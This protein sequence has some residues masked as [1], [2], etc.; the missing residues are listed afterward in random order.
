MEST[1]LL[2]LDALRESPFNPRRTFNQAALQELADTMKPPHGA[3][4]QP[5][6]VRPLEQ[7]DIEHSHEIVFG[8]RRCRAAR[9]AGLTVIPAIVRSMA[10][11]DVK[12]AQIVE[13]LQRE[14]VS[15][16]EE[17]DGFKTLR[18][19]HGVSIEVLM[20]QTGKS[21]S[22]IFNRLKLATAHDDVR[23]AVQ[24]GLVCAEIGQELAR[25]PNP[26]Q[27]KALDEVTYIDCSDGESRRV[28]LSV[29]RAKSIL[30]ERYQLKLTAAPF[31][32]LKLELVPGVLAC[33]ACPKRSDAEPTL[34]ADMGPDVC[35]DPD[36]FAAKKAATMAQRVEAMRAAGHTVLDGDAAKELMPTG[37]GFDLSKA[38]SLDDT[39]FWEPSADNP[40]QQHRVTWREAVQRG[41]GQAPEVIHV[42]HPHT[43]EL[44]EAI[45]ASEADALIAGSTD[46][47]DDE[48]AQLQ[49]DDAHA[50]PEER[51]V[52]GQE[53]WRKT[54]AAIM[55]SVMRSTTRTA[56]ELRLVASAIVSLADEVPPA[57][58]ELFGWPELDGC[59]WGDL[60]QLFQSK[61]Q[62]LSPD[63][64]GKLVVMLA[65]DAAPFSAG[66]V[67]TIAEK[68]E[69]ARRYGVDVLNPT[70]GHET[71]VEPGGA[72]DSANDD[73]P[74]EPAPETLMLD[75][76]SRA[77]TA[78]AEVQ[79]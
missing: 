39:A 3:V 57:V 18:M 65:L 68:L 27:P 6:V 64:L 38:C 51:A 75:V 14:D 7:S 37:F 43:G 25:V 11:E 59:K 34:L 17:A 62:S 49:N 56:D 31:D 44:V 2:S 66:R 73:A 45:R 1:V 71:S 42:V 22:Y 16:V 32:T 48:T 23:E 21:R 63:E 46:D 72:T 76:E 33:D 41:G 58:V 67:D 24:S 69:L 50:S 20:S 4:L 70:S 74:A 55:A 15:A 40:P 60:L 30:A 26:L 52:A 19:E 10:D 5:I 54:K 79:A 13:N 47:D 77:L 35:T 9:L 61:L 8:H 28:S 36:C 53:G 29:R 12:R 78:E